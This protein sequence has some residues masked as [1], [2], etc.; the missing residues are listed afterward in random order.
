MGP[1]SYLALI[2]ALKETAIHGVRAGSARRMSGSV[3]RSIALGQGTRGWAARDSEI[4]LGPE[5]RHQIGWVWWRNSSTL[6]YPNHNELECV[7]FLLP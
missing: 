1:P 4:E 7:L 2:A 6:P 3:S 5:G